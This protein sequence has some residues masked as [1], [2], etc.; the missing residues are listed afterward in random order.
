MH[1]VTVWGN[2]ASISEH[3]PETYAKNI[4]L[5]YPVTCAF[6][7]EKVRL[8]FSNFCG[9]EPVTLTQVTLA[10]ARTDREI[11]LHNARL[12]TFNGEESVTIPAGQEVFSDEIT[13]RIKPRG[14]ATVSIYLADFTLMRNGVVITGPL[15]KGFFSVGNRTL[16]SVLPLELTRTTSTFYFLSGVDVYTEDSNR[17]VILYGDSITA[18]SWADYFALKCLDDPYNTTSIVRRAA[19]GTRVLREYSCITYES[20]GLCGKNRFERETSTVSG[21]DTVIIQQ[22]INDIIHP[23]GTEINPFRPM[24]D[25][26]TVEELE[27]GIEYYL[28]QAKRLGLKTYLGTLLPIYGWR[29]YAPFREDMKNRFNDWIRT[30]APCDGCIDFDKALRSEENPAAFRQGFDSGD[31]LHP[32][33][34]AYQAM[35]NLAFE[36]VIKES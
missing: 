30:A 32:S 24:S 28:D 14:V 29:T 31:H 34:S 4:T 12:V 36:R 8:H 33:E 35:A 2:A 6:G 13:F 18:Q 15:S 25:L 19:S 27:A 1:W 23:V 9:T 3:R 10:N 5:R 21:A 20:Y 22:G 7:G 16:D 26:P 11:S 17:A